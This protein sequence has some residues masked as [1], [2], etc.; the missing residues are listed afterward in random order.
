MVEAPPERKTLCPYSCSSSFDD[1]V[2]MV[3]EEGDDLL[4]SRDCL[5]LEHTPISLVDYLAKDA[6]ST[7]EPPGKFVGRGGLMDGRAPS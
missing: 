6:Y 7:D 2:G 1:D 4:G 5:S 3:L